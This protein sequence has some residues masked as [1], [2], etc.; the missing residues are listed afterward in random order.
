MYQLNVY[1]AYQA[2]QR[3]TTEGIEDTKSIRALS[4]ALAVL[5]G[6]LELER[7]WQ[8]MAGVGA[9]RNADDALVRMKS[10]HAILIQ[11]VE[12]DQQ[13]LFDSL[14]DDLFRGEW[15]KLNANRLNPIIDFAEGMVNR[16]VPASL[17]QQDANNENGEQGDLADMPEL[18]PIGFSEAAKQ[19]V[20]RAK[21]EAAGTKAGVRCIPIGEAE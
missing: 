16:I 14:V 1:M 8:L 21:A 20:E 3:M 2:N 4:P 19:F 13:Q 9:D 12:P 10:A 17:A 18:E 11:I 7:C 15:H 5:L 6:R